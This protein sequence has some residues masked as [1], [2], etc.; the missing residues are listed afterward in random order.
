M[1]DLARIF[2]Y[3]A[4]P[5]ET[6]NAYCRYLLLVVSLQSFRTTPRKQIEFDWF[7]RLE[8]KLRIERRKR[9]AWSTNRGSGCGARRRPTGK[10]GPPGN[11]MDRAGE[12]DANR[13]RSEVLY[14]A[15][16]R[17]LGRREPDREHLADA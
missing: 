9:R 10:M 4:V 13:E 15:L 8:L 3:K 17:R 12:V 7:V 6:H 16:A 14:V 1:V 11:V 2:E 5:N